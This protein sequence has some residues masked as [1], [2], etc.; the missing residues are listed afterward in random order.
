MGRLLPLFF[1]SGAAGLIYEVV[2]VRQLG[3]VLGNTVYSAAVVT[4]V[5][6]LGLGVGSLVAGRL[7]DRR[8]AEDTRVPV[9]WYGLS[10]LLIGALGLALAL[11][12]P[13][14]DPL[15][16][17]LSS[18]TVNEEGWS[19]LS[20]GSHV[21]RAFLSLVLLAP[22]TLL[23][24]GTLTLLIRHVVATDTARAGRGI[25][26]LY[27]TNTVGAAIG[28]V[29][30]DVI[31]V[32][33][34]G[35]IGAQ[36][37]AVALNAVAGAL[38][39]RLSRT[40]RIDSSVE[41]RADSSSSL[42]PPTSVGLT[43]VAIALTGFAGMGLEIVWFRHLIS[44]LGATR[45]AFSILLATILV[46]IGAGSLVGGAI[47]TRVGRPAALFAATQAALV[48][49][50]IA[51]LSFAPASGLTSL[52]P[53]VRVAVITLLTT[54]VPSLMMGVSFPLANAHV[55]HIVGEVGR[56]AGLLYLFNTFG[57][58]LGS[59]I[60]G[61]V[62]L[63]KL[64]VQGTVTVVLFAST[65]S[66]VPL[67]AA[68]RGFARRWVGIAAAS[69]LAGAALWASLPS[70]FL[71]G[72]TLDALRSYR[73]LSVHEG[74]NE[75]LAVVEKD[76][77]SRRLMTNGHSM[78]GA[79]IWGQ[80][81]MRAF[82]HLPL[83]MHPSP[84]RALVICFGVGNTLDATL[85]HPLESVDV[86]D[87]S[88]DV[89]R[90]GH[91]FRD[92][93]GDALLDPRVSV[94]VNDGR[95]QLRMSE[96]GAYDLITLEPPPIAFM[97]VSALY[98]VE[99]YEL[100]KSKLTPNGLMTQW[101]PIY[102]VQPE[103]QLAAAKA[104]FEVF[105][106]AVVLSGDRAE[107]IL[108]G[109]NSGRI[110]VSPD[111]LA[112]AIARQP[113]VR[114]DLEKVFLATPRELLGM[115]VGSSRTLKDAVSDVPPLTDDWPILEYSGTQ[116]PRLHP[117]FFQPLAG[118]SD[119]CS[120]CKLGGGDPAAAPGLST[121]LDLLESYYSTEAFLG[122]KAGPPRPFSTSNESEN[123]VR[124]SLY[125]R[126]LFGVMGQDYAEATRLRR[127]GDLEAARSELETLLRYTPGHLDARVDLGE[128]FEQQGQAEAARAE[129]ERTI[130]I[131]PTFERAKRHLA[132]E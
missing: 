111:A 39:L 122:W 86:V 83:L 127:E 28:C 109:S 77:L 48:V 42:Q 12:L 92:T 129:F 82:A 38:A 119:L 47:V 76:G 3:N 79:N 9:R 34:I 89:L 44:V 50:A 14:L 100:A 65:M 61:Y 132:Q 71:L 112:A 69:A 5:F 18:Y 64:G 23:M 22:S 4:A 84:K 91:M 53:L 130:Q 63:P 68:T 36:T 55:Q 117:A 85:E 66:L 67:A 95:L 13:R 110:D 104:F 2:W 113:K 125:L 106:D 40:A 58:V 94:R 131:E 107:L 15:T 114:Q 17:S 120:S 123:V 128:I 62:L 81:Y 11:L 70:G 33:S 102:Q 126:F 35:L 57:A 99:F 74:V 97:G 101:L 24:G 27:A 75:T 32:R 105:E 51:S 73:I 41:S 124:E 72:R 25:G 96:D 46:G 8:F 80:R 16:Q 59:M 6:M 118:L 115:V 19:V 21:A 56:R 20:V 7:I 60:A 108:M 1:F 121:Y 87:L 29:L 31:L 54:G 93:N 43:A 103:A 37:I 90:H 98:S 45:P 116:K 10:E 49:S 26:I 78:S 52:P 30:T 88:E